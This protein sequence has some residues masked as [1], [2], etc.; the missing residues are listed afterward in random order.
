MK[1]KIDSSRRNTP[2]DNTEELSELQLFIR[3][4]YLDNYN[5][6]HPKLSNTKEYR[7]FNSVKIEY[8]RY[9]K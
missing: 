2:W 4:K 1:K 6:K 7:I 5:I 8:C 9:C 3:D